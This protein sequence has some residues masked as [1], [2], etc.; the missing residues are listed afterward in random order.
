MSRDAVRGVQYL[1]RSTGV[2]LATDGELGVVTKQAIA[3]SGSQ[4]LFSRILKEFDR[5]SVKP[6]EDMAFVSNSEL[7]AAIAVAVARFGSEVEPFLRLMIK[8]EN[9]PASDGVRTSFDGKFKGVGQFASETWALGAAKFP[10]VGSYVNVVSTEKSVLL[11]AWYYVDHKAA[12][13][14]LRKT[15]PLSSGYTP[16][17]AYLF[18]QQGAPAARSFLKTGRLVYPK[19]SSRSVALFAS[20][21]QSLVA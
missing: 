12:Y 4:E 15:M 11:A 1:L 9:Y 13:A 14:T 8:M 2:V 10:I 16:E 17:I 18:H 19:Q 3:N 20:L 7:N 21:H 6:R 5:P